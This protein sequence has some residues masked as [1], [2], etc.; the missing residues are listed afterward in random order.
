MKKKICFFAVGNPLSKTDN[1]GVEIG[2]ELKKLGEKVFFC[3]QNP[4]SYTKEARKYDEIVIVDACDGI[5][6]E[7]KIFKRAPET[8]STSTHTY[9]I[10]LVKDY[11]EN[12]GKNC[13]F[14]CVNRNEKIDV[15]K[16][17]EKIVKKFR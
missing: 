5:K 13:I 3:Y 8:I 15:K 14:F 1:I 2:A 12:L 16:M 10:N 11:L 9:N 7:F 4:E 6:G 17:A